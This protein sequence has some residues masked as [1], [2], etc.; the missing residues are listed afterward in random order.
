MLIS[1]VFSLLYDIIILGVAVGIVF[2]IIRFIRKTKN[3]KR[4]LYVNAEVSNR[5]PAAISCFACAAVGFLHYIFWVL[6]FVAGTKMKTGY[7]DSY[8]SS[9]IMYNTSKVV[10]SYSYN[11]YEAMDLWYLRN[12]AVFTSILQILSLLCSVAMIVISCLGILKFFGVIR[13]F[14]NKAGKHTARA[15]LITYTFIN[16]VAMI[17]SFIARYGTRDSNYCYTSYNQITAGPIVIVTFSVIAT[18][19]AFVVPMSIN[20]GTSNY[21][22]GLRKALICTDCGKNVEFGSSY[23]PSCGGITKEVIESPKPQTYFA[24]SQCGIKSRAGN[25]F[26]SACG[27]KV[28]EKV[29][30]P[31]PKI[32]Y[33]CSAC[34]KE[35]KSTEKFCTNCGGAVIRKETPYKNAVTDE[36]YKC[37]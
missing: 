29:I 32:T 30:A 10:S 9:Y 27:G 11:G 16:V 17:T 24:C 19:V 14:S 12:E 28:E 33:E 35:S 25:N 13:A 6:P 20:I 36:I 26:C 18:V 34:G 15:L 3:G 1:T 21:E 8:G 22:S 4:V 37:D 5:Y 7:R 31:P 23:C 2:G